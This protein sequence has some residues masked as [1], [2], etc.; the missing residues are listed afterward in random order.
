[1]TSILCY[2]PLELNCYQTLCAGIFCPVTNYYFQISF[3]SEQ[4]KSKRWLQRKQNIYPS[5]NPRDVFAVISPIL[6]HWPIIFPNPA[7][8]LNFQTLKPI[9]VES[10]FLPAIFYIKLKFAQ[11]TEEW[12]KCWFF[13]S[14]ALWINYKCH[15]FQHIWFSS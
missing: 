11:L 3:I 8:H 2:H 10:C 9:K 15:L 6:A 13:L 5:E 7:E 1:M 4:K 14:F 12:N